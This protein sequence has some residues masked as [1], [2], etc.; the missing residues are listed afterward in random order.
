MALAGIS[1][2]F[3]GEVAGSL[4]GDAVSVQVR[5]S[6]YAAAAVAALLGAAAVADVLYLNVRE[7]AAEYAL[8]STRCCARRGGATPPST[9][10]SSPKPR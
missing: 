5:S 1:T 7:R 3:E 2:A 10:S 9:A 8:P 4:L 6:D